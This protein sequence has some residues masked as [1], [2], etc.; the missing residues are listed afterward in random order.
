MQVAKNILTIKG[1]IKILVNASKKAFN[2]KFKNQFKNKNL[3]V[4]LILYQLLI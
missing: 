1:K 3:T 2:G 4:D